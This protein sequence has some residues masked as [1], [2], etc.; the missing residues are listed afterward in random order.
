MGFTS[1]QT[2][3]HNVPPATRGPRRAV[4]KP[5]GTTKAGPLTFGLRKSI[6][7]KR[8]MSEA[9]TP[10]TPGG[11]AAALGTLRHALADPLSAAGLKLELLERHLA[12]VSVDGASLAD[13][14][15]GVKA[16][17]A[18]TGRLIDLLPQ[19]AS[20]AGEA[21]AESS[22]GE[23]CRVAGIPIDE[24]AAAAET[25]LR[26]RR[27]VSVDVL[28]IVVG[29]VRS[30]DD[31]GTPPRLRAEASPGHVSLRIEGPGD[32][33]DVKVERLFLLPRG[34]DRAREL[35]LAR[36]GIETD[37]GRLRLE[38]RDG[39]FVALV[40]WPLPAADADVPA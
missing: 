10:D 21:P 27:L 26:L 29:F 33:G 13:R 7:P 12:A 19:L 9:L 1:G 18:I 28:R 22:I 8:N 31:A 3:A 34:E 6:L 37:G 24:G 16:D 20:M 38:G 25:R 17:L 5:G 39:R 40:S 23:L 14:V 15:R 30:L 2:N 35:F 32:P 11:M 36:A 4:E